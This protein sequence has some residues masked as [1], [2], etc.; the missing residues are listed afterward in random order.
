MHPFEYASPKTLK[1]ALGLL[2]NQ[3][4]EADVLAGGTDLLNL[5]KDELH[6]PKRLV[7]IKGIAA[8][9]GISK[10]AA[11]LR[12]GAI[13]TVDELLGS[14]AVRTEYPSLAQ[15]ARGIT[16]PQIRN[17]G[18]VGGDLCQRPRCWYFRMGY[19][20]LAM[21][22]GKSLVEG[23]ENKYHA[24]FHDGPAKFVSAS[25]FG[26]ALIALGAKL[27]LASASGTRE[28]EAAK[29]FIAPQNEGAREIALLPNEILTEI[30]VPSAAGV[31]NATYEVRQKDALDWPLATAS[32][33]LKMKGTAVAS[34]MIVLGHV[35]PTP[36][37]AA[38][39]AAAIQGKAVNAETAEAA[40]A[41]AVR[42]ARPLSGNAYKVTLAKTAVKRALLL[43]A[44][45]KAMA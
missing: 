5:L 11:G 18:T 2:G 3:W 19:G 27:K 1:E 20:L 31:K 21:K 10:T 35:G 13:A 43:A 17:M 42:D 15:A 28:V 40:A 26:P 29:W 30:V 41:A 16:S 37:V 7:N 25:S 34:A 23:G 6:A 24:I 12:I 33:A 22:D 44:T 38:D 32:V 39:A 14:A 36:Y 45:G 8:L 9:G 4:G